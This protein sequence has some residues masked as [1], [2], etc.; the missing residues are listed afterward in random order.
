MKKYLKA[1]KN[2]GDEMEQKRILLILPC[3]PWVKYNGNVW[4]SNSWKYV[5]NKIR[6]W[7]DFVDIYAIDCIRLKSSNKII[8]LWSPF[9]HEYILEEIL[10][11]KLD[12]YPSWNKYKNHPELREELKEEVRK[13]LLSLKSQYARI[14][15]VV[16]V[17]VYYNCLKEISEEF[18]IIVLPRVIDWRKP[19]ASFYQGVEELVSEIQKY[20]QPLK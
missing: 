1:S 9:K 18:N 19:Y 16:N 17:K 2:K 4:K 12:S 3:M 20:G 11:E 8:G 6:K 13:K 5:R 10:K 7:L 15:S 14:I